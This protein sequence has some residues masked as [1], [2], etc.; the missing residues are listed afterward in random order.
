MFEKKVCRTGYYS[1][2]WVTQIQA[3]DD[4]IIFGFWR[5]VIL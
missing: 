5:T 3:L 1:Q 4:M 2:P